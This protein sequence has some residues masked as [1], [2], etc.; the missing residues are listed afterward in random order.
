MS[1]KSLRGALISFEGDE[2]I[3]FI[4][5]MHFKYDKDDFIKT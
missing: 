4:K 5:K 1:K 2:A 3:C